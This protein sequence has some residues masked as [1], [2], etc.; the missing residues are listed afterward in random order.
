MTYKVIQ[1]ATGNVGL[2]SLRAIIERPDFE[3]VGLRTY[4][5]K[6]MGIDAGVLAGLDPV[7]VLATDNEEELLALDADGVAYNALGTT[8]DDYTQPVNDIVRLLSSG[9]NVVTSAVDY[10]LYPRLLIGLASER[11]LNRLEE[12]CQVGNTSFYQAGATPGFALDLWPL[13]MTRISRRIDHISVTELVD[14]STYTSSSVLRGYMGFAEPPEPLA[15]FMKQMIDV[16]NSTYLLAIRMLSD[17]SHLG[18][19]AVKFSYEYGLTDKGYD[20]PVGPVEPGTV[21]AARTVYSGQREGR[22][23]V[24]MSFVWRL[25]NDVRPDWPVGDGRWIVRIE[26]DPQIDTEVQVR[27]AFD[28]GRATSIMTAMA[29]LNG[30]PSVCAA[31]SGVKSHLD[32]PAFGGGYAV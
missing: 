23:V 3:L 30:L 18:V 31:S 1:W 5:S 8:L 26:G 16:D 4:D 32:L 15:P 2:H 28:T 7:G 13:T 11:D 6:K 22:E 17:A 27:T 9:K 20:S 10:Y 14:L 24:N 19:D 21:S 12:A 29:A 25:T